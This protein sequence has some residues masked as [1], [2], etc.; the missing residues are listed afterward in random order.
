MQELDVANYRYCISLSY[1]YGETIVNRCKNLHPHPPLSVTSHEEEESWFLSKRGLRTKM[2]LGCCWFGTHGRA[3]S[4]SWDWFLEHMQYVYAWAIR[5]CVRHL[6][7]TQSALWCVA[8]LSKQLIKSC[9]WNT[10]CS[11]KHY[12]HLFIPAVIQEYSCWFSS[13]YGY[14]V[15]FREPTRI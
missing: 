14:S 3:S 10:A 1:F 13:H 8:M 2:A 11:A 6:K 12:K 15:S 7:N 5:V 4:G 9:F